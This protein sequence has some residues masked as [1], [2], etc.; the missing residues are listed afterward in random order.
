MKQTVVEN[1]AK[2]II[3]YV[4]LQLQIDAKAQYTGRVS[5]ESYEWQR[6]GSI[7]AVRADDVPAL[8]DKKIN[9]YSCCGGSTKDQSMFVVVE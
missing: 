8:L 3:K 2:D 7:V 9:S 6:A 4:R 5:G 1:K